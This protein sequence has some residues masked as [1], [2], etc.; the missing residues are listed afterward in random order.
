MVVFILLL[1]SRS[2]A[3]R[4]RADNTHICDD[5]F[6][7]CDKSFRMAV[8]HRYAH[9][10]GELSSANIPSVPQ[11]PRSA[12]PSSGRSPKASAQAVSARL[13]DPHSPATLSN[14]SPSET[15]S[16]HSAALDLHKAP[17]PT[18]IPQERITPPTKEKS[19]LPKLSKKEK[20]EMALRG[21]LAGQLDA[22]T[23]RDSSHHTQSSVHTN[24][25][26]GASGFR[27]GWGEGPA[28]GTETGDGMSLS[29]AAE[30]HCGMSL[31][32]AG[33][34][35]RQRL[36][37][38]TLQQ[39]SACLPLCFGS[40]GIATTTSLHSVLFVVKITTSLHSVLFVVKITTRLHSVLFVVK[41]TTRLDSVLFVAAA[42]TTSLDLCLACC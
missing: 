9:E 42:M 24:S 19:P 15:P 27:H 26:T 14:K 11:T 25:T 1:L 12:R 8:E 4:L 36:Q 10:Y 34:T 17:C 33:D 35:S 13:A 5:Y 28:S 3:A 20:F 40:G 29:G 18:E 2:S 30:K 41:I 32:G 22:G 39:V 38:D 31:L 6:R 23:A 16:Q 37:A 7:F 21:E